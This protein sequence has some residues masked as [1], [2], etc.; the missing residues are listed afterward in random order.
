MK[1]V[2]YFLPLIV[3]AILGGFFLKGFDLNPRELAKMLEGQPVP[4][5]DLKPIKGRDDGFKNTDLLGEVSLVNIF[6]SWCVSC[7]VEHP[8]LMEIKKKGL[9]PIHGIDWRERNPDDGPRWLAKHGDPYTR[10]GDDPESKAAIAFGVSG[11]PESFLVDKQ[12]IVRYKHVGPVTPDVWQ[13]VLW[14][15]IQELRKR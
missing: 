15:L 10:V 6:G 4:E 2:V 13:K 5:F 7:Q 9:V 8:F 3:L 1:R 14:P 11:A 12:G